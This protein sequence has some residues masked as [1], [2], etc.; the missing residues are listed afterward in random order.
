[1]I[2]HDDDDYY[3]DYDDYDDYGADAAGAA[4]DGVVCSHGKVTCPF[5]GIFHSANIQCSLPMGL[6]AGSPEKSVDM[7]ALSDTLPVTNQ[8]A[9]QALDTA[10]ACSNY[11]KSFQHL[12]Q[13]KY[14]YNCISYIYII[15]YVCI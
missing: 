12:H 11:F 4:S 15:I 7:W 13:I 3:Y 10:K 8:R 5:H 2:N 1:M 9:L 6:L 14:I